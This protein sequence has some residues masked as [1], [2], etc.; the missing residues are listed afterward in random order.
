VWH[1]HG[2]CVER[3]KGC[4]DYLERCVKIKN[5]KV[6]AENPTRYSRCRKFI[7]GIGDPATDPGHWELVAPRDRVEE[8]CC[9]IPR[10][11]K[12]SLYFN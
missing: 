5:L 1:M 12:C 4:V 6:V 10:R 7:P 3:T 2:R 8:D 11:W 9:E